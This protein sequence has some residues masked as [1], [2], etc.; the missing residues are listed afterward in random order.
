MWA[1]LPGLMTGSKEAEAYLRELGY[2]DNG[3]RRRLLLST[4]EAVPTEVEAQQILDSLEKRKERDVI[5]TGGEAVK[6]SLSDEEKNIRISESIH[7]L[8]EIHQQ[9]TKLVEALANL[10]MSPGNCPGNQK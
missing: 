5:E 9:E 10:L 1:V 8:V 4:G 2:F 7:K 3:P 6:A